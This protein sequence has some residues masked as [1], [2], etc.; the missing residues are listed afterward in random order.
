[1]KIKKVFI[2]DNDPKFR[3]FINEFLSHKPGL[4]IVGEAAD[5]RQALEKIKDLKPDLLL[6]DIRI[7]GRGN[8]NAIRLFRRIIPDLK[9]IIMTIF[10]NPEYREAVEQSG[11]LGYVVKSNFNRDLMPLVRKVIRMK[12]K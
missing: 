3:M 1:M 11:A 8:F 12:G 7:R 10:D 6:A 4:K 5:W 9:V 2:I